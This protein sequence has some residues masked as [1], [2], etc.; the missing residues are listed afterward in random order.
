MEVGGVGVDAGDVPG[1]AEAFEVEG[2]GAADEAD[3]DEGEAAHGRNGGH[4][5]FPFCS[6]AFRPSENAVLAAPKRGF[7]TA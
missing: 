6:V 4:V 1:E 5:V 7:Q 3:A 2:E